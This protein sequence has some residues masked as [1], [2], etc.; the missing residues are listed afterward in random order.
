[1]SFSVAVDPTNPGQFFACC[2]LLEL[3]DRLWPGAEG[4]F[5]DGTFH[6]STGDIATLIDQL[7]CLR[8]VSSLG[9]DG[10]KRLGSLLS[11]DKSTL[12]ELDKQDKERLR[13]AWQVERVQIPAP[14]DFWLDWWWNDKSGVTLLK[15]W[16]AKQFVL[17]MANPMLSALKSLTWDSSS[18]ENCLQRTAKL[19]GLPFYFDAANNTQ[20]TPRDNG[21]APGAVKSAPNDRPLLELLAFVGLQRFRPHRPDKAER[22]LYATWSIPLPPSVASVAAAGM[23][24]VTGSRAFEFRML[25]RTEYMKAFLPAQAVRGVK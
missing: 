7:V 19:S 16:A 21:F 25:Y 10:L 20:N 2:G 1:M 23:L 24:N 8:F 12:T 22:I 17:S 5:E 4:W 14:F 18:R 11:A 3:A 13:K 6:V 9:D 15:T